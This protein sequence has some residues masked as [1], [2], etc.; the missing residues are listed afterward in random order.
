[1]N[2][3]TSLRSVPHKHAEC[4]K[5]WA[6]GA[7]IEVRSDG[8]DTWESIK[9]PHWFN[10]LEYRIKPQPVITKAYMHYDGIEELVQEGGFTYK[11]PQNLLFDSNN[12]MKEHL[13]MTFEDGKLTKVEM[14]NATN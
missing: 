4:I 2:T 9:N 8:Y 14:K 5:A 6:D 3:N 11:D 12:H 1:M 7:E 10:C 13:E